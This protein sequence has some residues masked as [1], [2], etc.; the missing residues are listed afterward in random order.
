MLDAC[1]G[2]GFFRKSD[3]DR[4]KNCWSFDE[5][6]ACTTID[7]PEG[8]AESTTF[9]ARNEDGPVM[10]FWA[11]GEEV[12][13]EPCTLA[14]EGVQSDFLGTSVEGGSGMFFFEESEVRASTAILLIEGGA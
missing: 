14:E 2:A 10:L 11:F 5:V 6:F 7:F 12:P 4:P 3:E 9:E 8:C 13:C 1:W